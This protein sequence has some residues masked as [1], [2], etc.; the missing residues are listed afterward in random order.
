MLAF[1]ATMTSPVPANIN[2]RGR[3][4]LKDRGS[5]DDDDSQ[6]LAS[7]FACLRSKSRDSRAPF[8]P[9][10]MYS[11]LINVG[12]DFISQVEDARQ[13]DL[14]AGKTRRKALDF[15]EYPQ[16]CRD[17]LSF[18]PPRKSRELIPASHTISI[19]N[20]ILYRKPLNS[21]RKR[22][23]Q[24]RFREGFCGSCCYCFSVFRSLHKC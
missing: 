5:E 20:G 10:A 14:V 9:D 22:L 19:M 11:K 15:D 8:S 17:P 6:G 1:P 21:C 23:G 7:H 13:C 24:L 3:C 16:P 2:W 12:R 4:K 18:T